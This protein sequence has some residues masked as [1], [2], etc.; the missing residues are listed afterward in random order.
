M[1]SVAT[2]WAFRQDRKSPL[3]KLLLLYLADV[4]GTEGESW[5]GEASLDD[6]LHFTQSRLLDVRQ[7]LLALADDGLLRV[8][9]PIDDPIRFLLEGEDDDAV[10]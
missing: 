2:A 9:Y 4:C 6:V 3:E 7:G 8:E 5:E 1:S 10:G